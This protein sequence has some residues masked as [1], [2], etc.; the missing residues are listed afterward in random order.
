MRF[1]S[2]PETGLCCGQWSHPS[3]KGNTRGK[4]GLIADPLRS[5]GKKPPPG[6]FNLCP[7][8]GQTY[9]SEHIGETHPRTSRC[10]QTPDKCLAPI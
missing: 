10:R 6:R 3:A 1:I 7:A 4:N 2:D 8:C 5:P 9:D